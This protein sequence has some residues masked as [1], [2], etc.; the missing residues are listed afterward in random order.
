MVIDKNVKEQSF[1]ETL[2]QSP[3]LLTPALVY[4]ENVIQKKLNVLNELRNISDTKILFSLKSM[5]VVHILKLMIDKLDGFSAS[6]LFEARLA[7]GLLEKKGSLQFTSPGLRA[8]EMNDIVQ[9]CDYISFNSLSQWNRFNHEVGNKLSC[10]LRINPQ[11][12]Y[13]SDERYDPC[14]QFSKLG[15][16]LNQL[17]KTDMR[18][19]KNIEGI[20]VHNNSESRDFGQLFETVKHII[21]QIPRFFENL[22]WMNLGGGYQIDE[23]IDLK[24]LLELIYMLNKKF[25][26]TVFLEPGQGIIR[27]TGFIVSRV[28]DMFRNEGR[29]IA[30]LDTTV[31]HMPGVFA[32]QE[33]PSVF[34]HSENGK[35]QYILAGATCLAGDLF[36]EYCFDQPLDIGSLILFNLM[37][38]C[39][40]VKANMFNGIN[41]P[42]IYSYTCDHEIVL[43]KNYTYEEFCLKSG[44]KRPLPDNNLKILT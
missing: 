31:N 24:P 15:I 22:R 26:L 37:G 8:D 30:V 43:I 12:S 27:D 4:D 17:L 36:G 34:N 40:L 25:N 23:D 20:S 9:S 35:W 3:D 33:S 32:Y 18:S 10:G 38:G 19:F 11:M 7:R 1:K 13:I 14:R 41:L 28:V 16:P 21:N 39:T 29:D 42:S 2:I 5:S 44:G 6:S